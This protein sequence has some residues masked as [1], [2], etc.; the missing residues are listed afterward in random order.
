LTGD[1]R[2]DLIRPRT[3]VPGAGCWIV[4]STHGWAA[5]HIEQ[6]FDEVAGLFLQETCLSGA[7]AGRILGRL[8]GV[9]EH[10]A[11]PI[12]ATA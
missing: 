9:E 7:A 8:E 2:D 4:H 3:A 6:P 11:P 1:Q 10:S 12:G 5:D